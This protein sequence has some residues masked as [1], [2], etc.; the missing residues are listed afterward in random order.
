MNSA[1]GMLGYYTGKRLTWNWFEPLGRGGGGQGT[2]T[3]CEGSSAYIEAGR[4][5]L[6]RG[7]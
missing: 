7:W 3:S 1:E 5:G 2:E 4:V 6:G